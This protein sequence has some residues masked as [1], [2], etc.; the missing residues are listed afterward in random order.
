MVEKKSEVGEKR[1]KAAMVER[2][3]G[4]SGGSK[5]MYIT[6]GKKQGRKE[7]K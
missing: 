5:G 7:K 1:M 3:A 4:R 6:K 2:K